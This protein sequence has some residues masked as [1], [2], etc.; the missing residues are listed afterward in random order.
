MYIENNDPNRDYFLNLHRD[1]IK[2]DSAYYLQKVYGE[3]ENGNIMQTNE[4][5]SNK[6]QNIF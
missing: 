6:N 4:S 1:I 5:K 2:K 3:D